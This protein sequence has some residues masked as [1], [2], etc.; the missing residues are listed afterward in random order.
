MS[1]E[2]ASTEAQGAKGLKEYEGEKEY[3][4]KSDIAGSYKKGEK[5]GLT[6]SRA[7]FWK[8]KGLI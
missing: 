5:V 1:K 7:K 6:Y 2:K 4:I 8:A 3:A